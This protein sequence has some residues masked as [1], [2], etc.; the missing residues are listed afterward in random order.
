MPEGLN[1]KA[2]IQLNTQQAE[3]QFNQMGKSL[4]NSIEKAIDTSKLAREMS[5]SFNKISTRGMERGLKNLVEGTR[6][7]IDKAKQYEQELGKMTTETE[8][9]SQVARSSD[10]FKRS[11]KDNG[12]VNQIT[13]K[14]LNDSVQMSQEY[15]NKLYK[16]AQIKDQIAENDAKISAGVKTRAET[17]D[18]R[19]ARGVS[20]TLGYGE[21]ARQVTEALNP[22]EIAQITQETSS[23]NQQL[24]SLYTDLANL[25]TRGDAFPS[26][27]KSM[28]MAVVALNKISEGIFNS[29]GR[30]NQ[31]SQTASQSMSDITSSEQSA[32][33]ALNQLSGINFAQPIQ[34]QATSAEQSMQSV[35]QAT[36]EGVQQVQQVVAQPITTQVIDT[37]A[38][39]SQIQFLSG[40]LTALSTN[41]RT[42]MA[43]IANAVNSGF[44]TASD[45]A[46]NRIAEINTNIQQLGTN[47]SSALSQMGEQSGAG[48][49]SLGDRIESAMQRMSNT[50]VNALQRINIVSNQ[51]SSSVQRVGDSARSA[52]SKAS[53]AFNGVSKSV[54][55]AF[56]TTGKL[57][58]YISGKLSKSFNKVQGAV[59][60]AFSPRTFKRALTT[61]LKYGIGVRSLYF[62]FRKLR[63][64]IKEGL[65]NLVQYQSDSNATNQAITAMNTS[66]LYL[67]NAW[68]SAFA[69]VINYVM[70]VLTSLI[71]KMAEV[72]NAIARFVGNLTG[73]TVVLNAVK[74]DAQ[75]YAESLKKAGSNAGGA[76]DKVRKL[77]D[78]LAGF[79]D[80]NVLGKDNDDD[81][82]GSGGGGGVDAYVPDPNDMFEYVESVSSFADMLRDAWEKEDFSG[83]GTALKDK[84]IEGLQGIDWE[85]IQANVMKGATLAGQ[86]LTGL[87]GDPELF[88]EAGNALG[89]GFNTI[90]LG[91]SSFL[92]E[93]EKIPLGDNLG[94]M[95]NEFLRTAD[96]ETAGDNINRVVT[97]LIGNID[98]F[99]NKL[100]SD[101]V[102]KAI[103]DFINGLDVGE[104][105]AKASQCVLDVAK[106]VI[107]VTGTLIV[108]WGNAVG[109]KW[110]KDA[111]E[112]ITTT[113]DGEEITLDPTFDSDKNPFITLVD[114]WLTE[115][116]EHTWKG[117]FNFSNFWSELLTGESLNEGEQLESAAENFW[118]PK[119]TEQTMSETIGRETELTAEDLTFL[120]DTFS[121]VG[122][123]ISDF[124][125]SVSTEAET[126]KTNASAQWEEIKTNVTTSWEEIKTNTETKW[127]ETKTTLTSTWETIKTTAESTWNTVKDNITSAVENAKSTVESK[128]EEWKTNLS[129]AWYNIRTT[130]VSGFWT[131]KSK[132]VEAFEAIRDS[133]KT[134]INGIISVVESMVNKVIE[135]IN[136][137]VDKLNSMPD[138]T[139]TNPFSGQSYTMGINLPHLN[140]VSIPRL[141]EGAVI[142]P[143]KEFMAVLG[144]QSN[145]TNIEAPLDTIKQA[146]AE[147]IAN[148]GNE[149]VIALLQQLITVVESKNLTIG[150]KEIGK[151]NARYTQQ[152]NLVRGGW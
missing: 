48:F 36:V 41:I 133:V 30:F 143:N 86:F 14:Y 74:V 119:D 11:G 55:K 44:Q 113:I 53:T 19:K 145:G 85:E 45:T 13:D 91:I 40:Q 78:R 146:V 58:S 28:E 62:A 18:E 88:K 93:V 26:L 92:D 87:F 102:V 81:T 63:N 149:Q 111:S 17:A 121:S 29:V 83:L 142:P 69:P 9:L 70:P 5:D 97:N 56:G 107:K 126:F 134:P 76:A 104:I 75:D 101:E 16:I 65:E 2:N 152:Q 148:N 96:F 120:G 95:V 25:E 12:I 22:Q 59:E 100:D 7:N 130:A 10:F 21:S 38:V 46:S 109:D 106:L 125:T 31:L 72:G 138:F 77:T 103:E 54:E 108:D 66:L 118:K 20:A 49:Q 99:V 124:F 68:A 131:M 136:S 4:S 140:Y 8:R 137:M 114:T 15:L 132:I 117:V 135:G 90:N 84:I 61:L 105:V 71:D 116:G 33:N 67:K 80:L 57:A 150:D 52:G 141:A 47:M 32:Q 73:Q 147:V 82:S 128:I 139:V 42:Q 43:D 94:E 64:A 98:A 37:S 24:S 129:D 6:Q 144:D 34:T 79:D 151:A 123:T 27:T 1:I 23:L 35:A 51:A 39:Q 112:G 89:E 50:I 127:E 122:T 60:K 3:Q 110:W 115:L